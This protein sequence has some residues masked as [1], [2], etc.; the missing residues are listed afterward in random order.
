MT[1]NYELNVLLALFDK[2]GGLNFFYDEPGGP[3][4]GLADGSGTCDLVF[5]KILS[6]RLVFERNGLFFREETDVAV[7]ADVGGG[8]LYLA[9]KTNGLS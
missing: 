6:K 3:V 9:R 4:E 1:L 5:I 2:I 8:K 7:V